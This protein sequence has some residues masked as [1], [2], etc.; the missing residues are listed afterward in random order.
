[1]TDTSRRTLLAGAAGGLAALAGCSGGGGGDG[2]DET[3]TATAGPRL[4]H[5]DLINRDEELHVVHLQV[6]RGSTVVY[7]D[8]HELGGDGDEQSASALVEGTWDDAGTGAFTVEALVDDGPVRSRTYA[9]EGEDCIG[10]F[11]PITDG[12]LD[13]YKGAVDCGPGGTATDGST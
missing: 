5:I 3:P 2:G 10:V 6:E 11:A 9:G 8:V 7:W 13:F 1:M 12:R 4:R